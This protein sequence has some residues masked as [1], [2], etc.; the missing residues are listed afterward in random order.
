MTL[1]PPSGP[2]TPSG[3]L[4]PPG[5]PTAPLAPTE[6]FT[7][8][9]VLAADVEPLRDE[10]FIG[11]DRRYLLLSLGL[12]GAACAAAV[13]VTAVL[14]AMAGNRGL[15]LLLG[16]AAL[17][18]LAGLAVFTVAS[19]RRWAYQLREHDVSVRRGVITLSVASVPYARVQHVSIR[20]GALERLAGLA[21]VD[22]NSAG[23]DISIPGLPV[24]DAERVRQLITKRAGTGG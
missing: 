4:H 1:P 22:V 24:H 13:V 12:V 14:A 3:A 6:P 16:G 19:F 23:P 15:V 5:A 8:R 20:R 21:T 7:N 2:P 17:L 10:H 11:L 18:L 9:P